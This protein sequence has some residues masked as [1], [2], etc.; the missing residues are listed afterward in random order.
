MELDAYIDSLIEQG[1]SDT[2]IAI[3][4][5]EFKANQTTDENFQQDGVA[6]AD[7]PSVSVAP[8]NTELSSENISLDLEDVQSDTD[9]GDPEM[10][11]KEKY[12]TP[13]TKEEKIEYDAWVAAESKRQG[14]DITWDL[15]TYDIQGFWKSGDH[16]KMDKDNHGSDKWK[17]PNHPTFSNQSKYHNVDGYVGGTWAEDGGY[18]PSDYTSKLYDKNYYDRLFGREPNRPEYLKTLS[19]KTYVAPDPPKEQPKYGLVYKDRVLDFKDKIV[20]GKT[21]VE[22][23][24]EKIV[25][26]Y[27]EVLESDGFEINN[28]LDALF[29]KAPNGQR[30]AFDVAT[31]FNR[32]KVLN[33]WIAENSDEQAINKFKEDKKN[34]NLF[35]NTAREYI[36]NNK[37][38][39]SKLQDDETYQDAFNQIKDYASKQV[40]SFLEQKSLQDKRQ[41]ILQDLEEG[42]ITKEQSIQQLTA[43]GTGEQEDFSLDNL[44]ISQY[45]IDKITN[46]VIG[47]YNFKLQQDI[48]TANEIRLAEVI[49]EGM[50]YIEYSNNVMRAGIDGLNKD[51]QS[52]SRL[53]SRAIEIQQMLD[54]PDL[55]VESRIVLQQ[56]VENLKNLADIQRDKYM[57]KDTSYFLFPGTNVVKAEKGEN[58]NGVDLTDRVF[59]MIDQLN[60][61]KKTDF[62]K[63]RVGYDLHHQQGIDLEKLLN[64]KV[65]V[66]DEDPGI[67]AE[68]WKNA[69]RN[70]FYTQASEFKNISVRDL[71]DIHI[72]S[73]NWLTKGFGDGIKIVPA[74]S[75]P[76]KRLKSSDYIDL[77]LK[78]LVIDEDSYFDETSIKSLTE[79][80]LDHKSKKAAYDLIYL[81]NIDP[82]DV[83]RDRTADQQ[84]LGAAATGLNESLDEFLIEASTSFGSSFTSEQTIQKV[85]G[86]TTGQV[87]K[88]VEKITQETGIYDKGLSEEQKEALK[89]TGAAHYGNLSGSLPKLGFDFYLLNLG[90]GAILRATRAGE[91]LITLKSGKYYQNVRRG[92]K[93]VQEPLGK[94]LAV[95]EGISEAE[96]GRRVLIQRAFNAGY[97]T[98]A[99]GKLNINSQGIKDFLAANKAGGKFSGRFGAITKTNPFTPGVNKYADTALGLVGKS[100]EL[101]ATMTIEGAKMEL[102]FGDGGFETGMAF[103]P[104]TRLTNVAF[105]KVLGME[106]A[107]GSVFHPLNEFIVKPAKGGF[108]L[109]VAAETGAGLEGI[110]DAVVGEK[111][112]KTFMDE[113]YNDVPW[114]GEGSIF[115]RY[116]GHII[117]GAGLAYSHVDFKAPFGRKSYQKTKEMRDTSL[118]DIRQLANIVDGRPIAKDPKD[119]RKVNQLLSAYLLSNRYIAI[120]E[121]GLSETTPELSAKSAENQ[122]NKVV[123]NHKKRTGEDLN[124]SLNVSLDGRGMQGKEAFIDIKRDS[125]GKILSAEIKLDARKYT[126]GVVSHEIGHYF[127]ELNGLNSPK[128]LGKIREFVDSYVQNKIGRDILQEIKSGYT[129]AEQGEETYEEEYLMH[130]VRILGDGGSSLVESNIYGG[131][132]GKI[133]SMFKKE[134]NLELQIETP[135]QL[136]NI[137]NRLAS[138][139]DVSKEYSKLSNL[140]IKKG[141]DSKGNSVYEKIFDASSGKAVGSTRGKEVNDRLGQLETEIVVLGEKAS[142][143][144]LTPAEVNNLNSAKAEFNELLLPGYSKKASIELD[145]KIRELE[146]RFYNGEIS[147]IE[148]EQQIINEKQKAR[149]ITGKTVDVSKQIDAKEVDTKEQAELKKISAK[150]KQKLDEIGNDN[151]GYKPNNPEIYTLLEGMIESKSRS[152]VTTD[153]RRVNLEALSGF[154]MQAMKAETRKEILNHIK[155]FDPKRNNSL[156]GWI[157]SQLAN[158]MRDA[159]KTGNVTSKTFNVD[160]ASLLNLTGGET[161]DKGINLKEAGSTTRER[162]AVDITRDID[163]LQI[164]SISDAIDVTPENVESIN[165]EYINKNFV[166]PI[167]EILYKTKNVTKGETFTTQNTIKDGVVV[168]YSD[169]SKGLN[170]FKKGRNLNTHLKTLPEFNVARSEAGE[171]GEG[172]LVSRDVRGRAVVKS[173]LVKKYFYEPYIDPKAESKEQKAGTE[174]LERDFAIT[175]PKGRSKGATSQT[176]VLRLKP[177]FRGKISEATEKKVLKDLEEMSPEFL[178]GNLRLNAQNIANKVTRNKIEALEPK[179]DANIEQ[180]LVD[181]KSATSQR[182]ASEKLKTEQLR[183]LL[184][185]HGFDTTGKNKEQMLD[186]LNKAANDERLQSEGID[187]LI[188]DIKNSEEFKAKFFEQHG[189][190][191]IDALLAKVADKNQGKQN[192]SFTEL[193]QIIKM[194][195]SFARFLPKDLGQNRTLVKFILGRHYRHDGTGYNFFG[196]PKANKKIIDENGVALDRRQARNMRLTN[197]DLNNLLDVE[198]NSKDY[199][200]R[201]RELQKDLKETGVNVEALEAASYQRIKTL[202]KNLAKAKTPE[203]QIEILKKYSE[204]SIKENKAREIALNLINSLKV[205][206]VN[207]T[208]KGSKQRQ[209]ALTYMVQLAKSTNQIHYGEKSLVKIVGG[210]TGKGPFYLEHLDTGLSTSMAGLENIFNNTNDFIQSRALLLPA[211]YSKILDN[212]SEGGMFKGTRVGLLRLL[213][214]NKDFRKKINDGSLKI[215]D[216]NNNLID[217]KNFV[218]DSENFKIN[219]IQALDQQSEILNSIDINRDANEMKK[220]DPYNMRDTVARRLFKEEFENLPSSKQNYDNLSDKQKAAVQQE[221]IDTYV[222]NIPGFEQKA[223]IDINKEIN[224]MIERSTNFAIPSTRAVSQTEAIMEGKSKGRFDILIR[225]QAEDFVGLLYKMLGKGEQ[226]NADMAFFKRTLLDPFAKAMANISADRISLL[227]DY[228]AIVSNLKV[229]SEKGIKG[230]FKKSPL[231]KQVGDTGFTAE[232][233]VRAYVWTK[234]GMK[235]PGLSEGQLKK[236]LLHVKENKRLIT[237]GNQL[238]RINKGDGYVKPG[239]NWLSGTIGTDIL[240]GLN[241]TKRSKYLEAWQKNVDV[242][243]SPEN[244]NKLQAAYGKPYVDAMKNVLRRMKTGRNRVATGDTI[245]QRFTDFIAQATGSIMFLN[246]RSAVLQTISSLNFIN[247]GDNNIFAAGKAFANQKQYWK[248]FSK[249]FNS[250]F[251]KDRRAGLRI[252]VI[253]RDIATAARRGG[254][255]GVTARLLQSG[256]TPT[257][258]ADSFAIAAGGSTFYRNRIKTYEKQTDVDGNKIYT[259]EQAEQKAFQDFRENAEESQQ[260]SRP[261]RISAEQASGLGRHVLAFANTPAQ[262]ARIIKKSALDL[263]NGRGDAKTNISKIVYYTFAQNVIFNTL[264]QAIFA[265]AFDDD[266][267]V[268]EDKTI[269]LANGMA[270]SILRG[271]GVY[272]SVFAAFKDV[273]I[274]LYTESKKKRPE[275]QK[276]GVQ[277]LNIAPPAGSKYKKLV[278]GLANFSYTT[279]EAILEK[280]ISLD[281]PGIRGAARVIEGTTN[282]PTDRTLLLMDQIQGALDQDLEYWQR[283]FIGAGWQDW[284]LGIK[285]KEQRQESTGGFRRRRVKRRKVKRR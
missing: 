214:R 60:T 224:D 165:S 66:Y 16:M 38:L 200:D 137:I 111:S 203:E 133:Q 72:K 92:G 65:D 129:G 280:G 126:K 243:F 156:Y 271:M 252:N 64:Q 131:L 246:S 54:S 10:I 132:A 167:G 267:D 253:E 77:G 187:M 149:R 91:A 70:K 143:E 230:V 269:N 247:F 192:F 221:M 201:T 29:I 175:S 124:L 208:V 158:K 110:A 174:F 193:K 168:E 47:E 144:G 242:M 108:S 182:L 13:L 189:N 178:R 103:I 232:Q 211:K 166:A 32:F 74:G 62:G 80:Y 69:L 278:G 207:S 169:I 106:F 245:T 83:S 198:F 264:Q 107:K 202:K 109:M 123:K 31:G 48:K 120:A 89:E 59:T 213:T 53:N 262:Y 96:A 20:K 184:E 162:R 73:N 263:K 121:N 164:K 212:I 26:Q 113:N 19:V 254:I 147:D 134:S 105:K 170:Y 43:I 265:T 115:R 81:A 195:E 273:G 18:T 276:A 216:K 145:D 138:G 209:E 40:P 142:S 46:E 45:H 37:A 229:P 17:K 58:D 217:F 186:M 22:N 67:L 270:N 44:S 127:L 191:N 285:D 2:E 260:S 219:E 240:E 238:I 99:G 282:L 196:N 75:D 71:L 118:K 42:K 248:D 100:L 28:T 114:L 255:R 249:L 125:N 86:P 8:E 152:F 244:L 227:S 177:E 85:F 94:N 1:L 154:N 239:E 256:F 119:Q 139:K 98:K 259:K 51:M 176:Q 223:S 179:F 150:T 266:L 225:P 4:I 188:N 128:N 79:T 23:P 34:R 7:A 50:S 155:N 135:V 27:K 204:G 160:S 87:L 241:T 171:I 180:V 30:L 185:F 6:G 63:L 163:A 68:G 102:L 257:Q 234:Q 210:M 218:K 90:V 101:G 151:D 136:L 141:R 52:F 268:T 55:P 25:N 173:N 36:L 284:Q 235:I 57:G 233:A 41:K 250:D 5:Q 35:E 33:D 15:G 281:N 117:T 237:F 194:Q 3:K 104:A 183:D 199:S 130:L 161:A 274:K 24:A 11:F 159:L 78:G 157:N 220:F 279:P 21:I 172:I 272:P 258:I 251:L 226:G 146:D 261:D 76:D 283:A 49:G 9:L 205:D 97:K 122:V 93:I 95:A 215:L 61:V 39:Q 275:Y 56:Q 206:F 222:A 228:K 153:N 88:S 231:K 148:L 84:Y 140:V 12:N 236:L 181:I 82:K 197:E 14:R 112:F 277:I 116:F 190:I